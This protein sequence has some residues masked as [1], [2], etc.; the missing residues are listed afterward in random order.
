MY[1]KRL[2]LTFTLAITFIFSGCGSDSQAPPE[3]T[4]LQPDQ[5]PPGTLVTINGKNFSAKESAVEVLFDGTDA[6]VESASE[7]QIQATVPEGAATGPITVSID[8]ERANGPNFTVEA[9]A[10]G[11]YSV[12][13]DSGVAGTEVTITGVNFSATASENIV[14]FNG[15]SAIVGSASETEL[16][17]KVPDGTTD[18]PIEVTV[19]QKSTSGP[20]F[21]VI[22]TGTLAAVITTSGPDPDPDGYIMSVDGLQGSGVDANDTLYVGGLEERS[23]KAELKELSS[24]CYVSGSNPQAMNITATDTTYVTF[25]VRCRHVLN[26]TI[27]FS[28]YRDGDAEIYLMNADGSNLQ[29]VTNNGGSDIGLAISPDGTQIAFAS[30]RNGNESLYVMDADGSNVHRLSSSIDIENPV[31]W[32][33]NGNT[34]AFVSKRSGNAEIYSIN[35]DGLSEQRLT[36]NSFVDEAPGWSPDGD[37]ITFHSNRDGDFEIYTMNTE[38]TSLKQI[39]NDTNNNYL[40]RWSPDGSKYV[41]HSDR[42][43]NAEIYVMNTEGSGILRITN[44][45]T[46]DAYAGWSPDGSKLVFQTSRD[47]NV[48][49]YKINS[50]GS[51]TPENLT[52]HSG[53]D[54][55]PVWSPVE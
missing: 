46:S 27:M 23:H 48:E 11:I 6:I 38:G 40:P 44:S 47:G 37:R 28:S 33:P 36:N 53:V 51:G 7:A 26:N 9:K 49:I 4:S 35:T 15:T 18:G 43:G 10:P 34:I 21:D 52:T 50:D 2:L 42:D 8:G 13:P 3:I 41:F 19:K 32:S 12:E 39:T 16:V 17:T 5:G 1:S 45:S 20:I 24:N 22:T 29:K 31:A 14:T 30:D 55:V 25:D 54:V